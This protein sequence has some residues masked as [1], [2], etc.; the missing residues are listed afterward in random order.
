MAEIQDYHYQGSLHD[1]PQRKVNSFFT[2]VGSRKFGGLLATL[3]LAIMLPVT[4]IALSQQQIFKQQASEEW[5]TVA[6]IAAP[7]GKD[8]SNKYFDP[9]LVT[10]NGKL[11]AFVIGQGKEKC[12]VQDTGDPNCNRSEWYNVYVT[13]SDRGETGWE[14]VKNIG[15][16][17][18]SAPV[19]KIDSESLMVTIQGFDPISLAAGEGYYEAKRTNTQDFLSFPGSWSSTTVVEKNMISA[20]L[21]GSEYKADTSTGTLRILRK[22]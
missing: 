21:N 16:N 6:T 19:V 5:E 18:A 7:V 4:L 13:S 12:P 3:V 14:P 2:K 10:F 17:A 9:A 22:N 15:G 8:F 11:Y 1:D 20:M